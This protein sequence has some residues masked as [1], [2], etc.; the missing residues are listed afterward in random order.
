MRSVGLDE[1]AFPRVLRDDL[2]VVVEAEGHVGAAA[3]GHRA[4][5]LLEEVFLD[6]ERD[7]EVDVLRLAEVLGDL[8]HRLVLFLVVAPVPPHRE[9]LL[10]GARDHGEPESARGG[11]GADGGG[12][13]ELAA[14][15]GHTSYLLWQ[16]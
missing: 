4:D 10:L 15:V 14:G 13:E 9:L 5:D 7:V 1:L 2:P 11:A 6:G 12:L 16:A 8:Q 3:G